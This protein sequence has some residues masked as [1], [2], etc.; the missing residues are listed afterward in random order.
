MHHVSLDVLGGALVIWASRP[1]GSPA[2]RTHQGGIRY[3]IT[4]Y[5]RF[6]PSYPGQYEKLRQALTEASPE[7]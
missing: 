4:K 1:N 5:M 2:G 7:S 6:T 3:P